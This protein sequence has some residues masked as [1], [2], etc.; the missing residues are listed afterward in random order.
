M[1]IWVTKAIALVVFKPRDLFSKYCNQCVCAK[2]HSLLPDAYEVG[3]GVL[4]SHPELSKSGTLPLALLYVPEDG[5]NNNYNKNY[6]KSTVLMSSHTRST[7]GETHPFLLPTGIA[8]LWFLA[9]QTS[10]VLAKK[11]MDKPK[12][13]FWPTQYFH[14]PGETYRAQ[15]GL[16][17]KFGC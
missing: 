14:S 3:R 13:T 16:L 6:D 2:I 5:N 17:F 4:R 8:R 9:H 10:P 15:M 7:L 12:W 11:L 1:I